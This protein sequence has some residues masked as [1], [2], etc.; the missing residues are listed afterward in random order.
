VAKALKAA[1]LRGI[2]TMPTLGM[3]TGKVPHAKMADL[4]DVSGVAAVEL[5][6]EMKAT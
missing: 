4:K 6:E 1:G 3:I 5:D 2:N